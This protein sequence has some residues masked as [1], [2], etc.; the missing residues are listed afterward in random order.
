MNCQNKRAAAKIICLVMLFFGI[1][2]FLSFA[3]DSYATLGNGFAVSAR[4]MLFRNG[5]PVT[6]LMYEL[7]YLSGLPDISFYYV[8]T[9]MAYGF[10]TAS[11]YIY[12]KILVSYVA[13]EN[14]RI[15]LSFVT[16]ANLFIIEYFM[17]IEKGAFLFAVLWNVIGAFFFER[18]LRERDKKDFIK[19]VG[20]MCVAV[21]TYQGTIAL[22]VILCLP[23]VYKHAKD[24][25]EY[26]QNLLWGALS[27]SLPVLLNLLVFRLILHSTRIHQTPEFYEHF[28]WVYRETKRILFETFEVFPKYSFVA[29]IGAV[30]IVS[31]ILCLR[32][33]KKLP[34]ILHLLIT[35]A[36]TGLF[37]VASIIQGS[38]FF[39]MR[40]VYP[41]ASLFGI[42]IVNIYVNQMEEAKD[43]MIR[44]LNVFLG[45]LILILL[46]G[47]YLSF[48]K[49]YIDKYKLNFAD[50]IRCEMIEQAISEYE[51][52]S[53]E[54]VTQIAFYEDD[55]VE[56]PFYPDLYC[57]GDLIY[58]SFYTDWS[59]LEA[60]NYY[61]GSNYQKA[62]REETYEKY[63]LDQ[64]W[65]CWSPKQMIFA[66]DTLHLCVY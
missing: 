15:L 54:T 41:L 25:K 49:I 35:G 23:F 32:G 55:E 28:K 37:S 2:I 30:T 56:M 9:V 4:D 65:D 11:V 48:N 29:L 46:S 18:F 64:D 5:R 61:L 8:S 66:E 14:R 38:G 51:E 19:S 60:I 36:A 45:I 50:E 10:L 26:I 44:A 17:F 34:Q 22:F 16:I 13:D 62:E 47:Q 6:A 42:L 24:V 1:N 63:F 53:G 52:T 27:C 20:S 31:L 7:H 58:S 21:F 59:N 39:N 12:Q 40:V 43:T 3:T 57:N 33:K